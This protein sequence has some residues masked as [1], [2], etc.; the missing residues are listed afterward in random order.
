[1]T[2]EYVSKTQNIALRNLKI[3]EAGQGSLSFDK[4]VI[5]LNRGCNF[6][7]KG[8]YVKGEGKNGKSL[9]FDDM[10]NAIRFGGD[11]GA[12][13]LVIPGYGEPL[14]DPDLWRVV[15]FAKD[16]GLESVIY[17]NAALIDKYSANRLKTLQVTVI[18]K[19]NTFNHKLQDELVRCK[20]ASLLM[21][22]GLQ[23]LLDAGFVG[24]KLAIESYVIRPLLEDLKDVLRFCRRNNVLPYFEAFENSA[25]SILEE[26]LLPLITDEELTNFF[27]ELSEID[28]KEFG[29]KVDIPDGERIYRF[30][31]DDIPT[32]P[33]TQMLQKDCCDRSYTSF[34]VSHMGDVR[35]CVD[36]RKTVG[37][38]HDNPIDFILDPSKN[39]R[40]RSTF[41]KPCSYQTARFRSSLLIK[42][43]INE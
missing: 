3:V 18:A 15:E 36:H 8:C 6:N 23:H 25:P 41:P 26:T 21:K 27:Y 16:E 30:G 7:C 5:F 32:P 9:S 43:S 22:K 17:T 40:L 14:M 2:F 28:R 42:D 10:K 37:N 24:P 34:C 11:R 38:I 29:I 4:V 20:G 31:P 1:M 35:F 13:F 39:Q 19:R 12:R 33:I